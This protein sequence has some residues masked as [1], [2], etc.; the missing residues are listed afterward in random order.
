[1]TDISFAVCPNPECEDGEVRFNCSP[2]QDPQCEDA[3]ACP[4]CGGHGVVPLAVIEEY[5]DVLSRAAFAPAPEGGYAAVEG[6]F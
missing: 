4:T 6:L 5:I 2:N 1:M 3:M